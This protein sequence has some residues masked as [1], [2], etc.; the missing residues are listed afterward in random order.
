MAIKDVGQR[1]TEKS[2]PLPPAGSYPS[3]DI[4]GFAPPPAGWTPSGA[5]GGGGYPTKTAMPTTEYYLGWFMENF[6]NWKSS[7]GEV[8]FNIGG[9]TITSSSLVELLQ[10]PEGTDWLNMAPNLDPTMVSKWNYVKGLQALEG[11]PKPRS[12]YDPTL[13]WGRLGEPEK[14]PA[15]PPTIPTIRPEYPYENIYEAFLRTR[16]PMPE[17][18]KSWMEQIFPSLVGKFESARTTGVKKEF[19]KWLGEY[20]YEKYWSQFSPAERGFSWKYQP[21][22]RTASR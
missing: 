18:K 14:A 3:L 22:I 9:Q 8:V 15:A 20:P 11:T 4:I 16:Q 2:Q 12:I 1:Q 7:T 10:T 5:G 19:P 13:P 17:R 21:K 6:K